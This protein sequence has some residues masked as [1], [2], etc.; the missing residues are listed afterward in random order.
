MYNYL[1]LKGILTPTLDGNMENVLL[2]NYNGELLNENKGGVL[3]YGEL[4]NR[5]KGFH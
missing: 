4:D 5:K 2:Y 3:I 1:N